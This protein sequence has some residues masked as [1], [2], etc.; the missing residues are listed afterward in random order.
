M[1]DSD[2]AR[3]AE[4]FGLD[5]VETEERAAI[6]QYDGG[7]ERGTANRR[8]IVGAVARLVVDNPGLDDDATYDDAFRALAQ[9]LDNG[10]AGFPA[11]GA[12]S[13]AKDNGRDAKVA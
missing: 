13:T 1:N 8:A 7:L 4:A 10:K 5:I 11:R 2:L 3:L 12:L 6:R 9:V